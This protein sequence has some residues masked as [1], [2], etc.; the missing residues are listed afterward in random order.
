MHGPI[1]GSIV[2]ASSCIRCTVKPNKLKRQKFGEQKGLSQGCARGRVSHAL[3]SP[4]CPRGFQQSTL[5]SQVRDRGARACDPLV[6]GS[7]I[8]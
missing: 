6:Y 4:E 7:L 2:N 8:D 5:K 1:T 3:K